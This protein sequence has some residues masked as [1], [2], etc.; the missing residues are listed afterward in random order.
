MPDYHRFGDNGT[1]STR[2]RQS[3]QSDHQTN[4]YDSEVAH[5]GNGINSSKITALKA[6]CQFAIDRSFTKTVESSDKDC[7][8]VLRSLAAPGM[9]LAFG[10]ESFKDYAPQPGRLAGVRQ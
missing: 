4:E 2:P 7:D 5:S 3:G 6:I 9:G 8:Q 1:E 10:Q